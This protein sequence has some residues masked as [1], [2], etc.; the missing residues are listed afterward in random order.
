MQQL[1]PFLRYIANTSYL[2]NHHFTRSYDCRFLYILAGSGI[3][4]TEFGDF[5]L[6]S[7][8]F[9]YYPAGTSYYPKSSDDNPLQFITANFDFTQDYDHNT[10]ILPPV[11]A[12]DFIENQLQPSQ[13][14]TN[15]ELFLKPF[16]ISPAVPIKSD[17]LRLVSL[18]QSGGRFS[19]QRCSAL[20]ALILYEVFSTHQE[21]SATSPLVHQVKAFIS[22]HYHQALDNRTIADALKYHP[23]YLN[24]IFKSSCGSTIHKYLQSYRLAQSQTLILHTDFPLSSIGESCG[25]V[26]A[27]HFSRCFKQQFGI[28]PSEYRKKYSVI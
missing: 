21:S 24:S 17:L 12:N 6:E 26:S 27:D 18:F 7:D 4:L 2:P 15:T 19:Q 1:T 5:P 9:V 3:L 13:H 16:S 28:T 14:T 20:L 23:Y 25:F 11:A 22:Q 10:A 8:T